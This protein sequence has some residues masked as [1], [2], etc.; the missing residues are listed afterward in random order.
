MSG[1]EARDAERLDL[2]ERSDPVLDETILQCRHD[3]V[4]QHIAGDQHLVVGQIDEH[5]S[6]RVRSPRHPEDDAHAVY[7]RLPPGAPAVGDLGRDRRRP[8]KFVPDVVFHHREPFGA[9]LEDQLA[10]LLGAYDRRSLERR[11]SEIVVAVM[12]RVDDM[13]DR[14]VRE[15]LHCRRDMPADRAR[16]AR[17]DQHRALV[18]H[19]DGRIDHVALVRG[20]GVLDRP[21][22]DV[23][24]I[25]DADDARRRKWLALRRGGDG[26]EG[27]QR[28]HAQRARTASPP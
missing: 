7:D 15:S 24:P 2:A 12:V 8:V 13:R 20:I 18:A 21:E 23:H 14:L 11:I 19:D 16:A 3:P 28:E 25:V 22:E 4:D 5:V 17:V 9:G 1:H 6:G 27:G 10:A 26:G